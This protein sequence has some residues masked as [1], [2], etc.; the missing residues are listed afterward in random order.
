MPIHDVSGGL[1]LATKFLIFLTSP[2]ESVIFAF[3]NI[4]KYRTEHDAEP[5]VNV[6]DGARGMTPL[7]FACS[8]NNKELV[9]LLLEAGANPVARYWSFVC[10]KLLT[11]DTSMVQAK[12]N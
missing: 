6:S 9:A 4:Q 5:L 12:L 2:S 7:H 8:D 3:L 11:A 1:T 10:V